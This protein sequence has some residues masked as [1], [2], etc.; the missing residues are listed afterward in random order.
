[1]KLDIAFNYANKHQIGQ[2]KTDSACEARHEMKLSIFSVINFI[3]N[4][5]TIQLD[6]LLHFMLICT[7]NKL[8][9]I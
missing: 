5:T 7:T 3:W 9:R 2:P 1:V 6:A 8:L 4:C